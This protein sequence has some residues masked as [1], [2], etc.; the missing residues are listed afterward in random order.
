MASYKATITFT[1]SWSA[2]NLETCTFFTPVRDMGFALHEIYE[3]SGLV[4]GDIPY[5]EYNVYREAAPIEEGCASGLC[6]LLG[7]VIPF[8][9]LC[10]TTGWRSGGFRKMAWASYLFQ[11][12]NNKTGP[13]TRLAPSTDVLLPA[14]APR[15]LMK[16]PSN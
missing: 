16:T 14:R 15:N 5:E 4:M 6:D 10:Q 1:P 2:T 11:G 12:L 7:S 3:V 8:S 13:V 9:D